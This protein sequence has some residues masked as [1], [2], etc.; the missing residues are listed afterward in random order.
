M[1][2]SEKFA[3][4]AV[5]TLAGLTMAASMVAV[6]LAAV[7]DEAPD[8][9]KPAGSGDAATVPAAGEH[10]QS[11]IVKTAAVGTFAYDQT[12]VSPIADIAKMQGASSTLCGAK[13]VASTMDAAS[14]SW[15]ITVSGDVENEFCATV[16]EL[17]GE[18]SVNQLMT[19][20]CGGNPAGGRAIV[21][22]EVT[23]VSLAEIIYKAQPAD[24]VN[25]VTLVSD[26]GYRMSIPLDY[27]LARRALMVSAVNGADLSDSMGG[28]NQIWM[29]ATAAKYFSR[30]VV[31]VELT[32]E[33]QPPAAPGTED[34]PDTEYVN[35]P[36]AGITAAEQ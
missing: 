16:D 1:K 32:C 24:D 11:G 14:L 17:V 2:T 28:T 9:G 23:G 6:P 34:A 33:A 21:T 22:A 3:P 8:Q 10:V 13:D 19:C 27:V 18:D 4:G 26:D 36:N 12:T 35:R 29:D 15:T 7:A 31:A 5:S 20:S 30:N 25:T